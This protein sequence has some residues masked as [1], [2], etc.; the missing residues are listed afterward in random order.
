MRYYDIALFIFI[1][2]LTLG[3]LQVSLAPYT[4][5]S[6]GEAEGFGRADIATGEAQIA[7]QVNDVYTP[8]WSELN[9][10]V[11]NVRLVVQGVAT[12]ILTLSKATI[13]F[14]LLW[15]ELGA[16]YVG[17]DAIWISFVAMMSSSFY[18]IYFMAIL[19]WATGRSARDAQ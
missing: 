2:N 10:L 18:F 8:I 1:F 5:A 13:F 19:Q 4:Q 14:P 15:Y 11:E 7:R 17:A 3:F 9:W 12:F 6:I 16:A